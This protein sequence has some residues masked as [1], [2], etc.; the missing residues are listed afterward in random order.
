MKVLK[1]GLRL[2]TKQPPVDTS[3]YQWSDLIPNVLA[4]YNNKNKHRITGMTPTEAKKPSNEVDAKMAMELVA[5][6]GQKFQILNI[7]DIVNILRNIR[8]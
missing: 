2:A 3:Q 6:R 4:E 7:G 8:R 1:R 5:R